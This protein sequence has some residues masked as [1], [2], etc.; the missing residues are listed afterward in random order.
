M[1]TCLAC[2]CPRLNRLNFSR[3]LLTNLGP[4]ECLPSALRHLNFSSNKLSRCFVEFPTQ[5]KQKLRNCEAQNS[6][7]GIQNVGVIQGNLIARH[8]SELWKRFVSIKS[9]ILRKSLKIGCPKSTFIK[10]C[11]AI[12]WWARQKC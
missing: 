6:F 9:N 5:L 1:P 12:K 11:S 8:S 3:N 2:C 10:C 4:I 7:M